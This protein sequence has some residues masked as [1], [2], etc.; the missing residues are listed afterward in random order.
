M[1]CYDVSG[2]MVKPGGTK[3]SIR[4][5][6]FHGSND[7][8]VTG[9]L[10]PAFDSEVGRLKIIWHTQGLRDAFGIYGDRKLRTEKLPPNMTT[11]LHFRPEL[12]LVNIKDIIQSQLFNGTLQEAYHFPSS[13]VMNPI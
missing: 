11:A 4:P 8:A 7:T 1:V 3:V 9:M 5:K 12:T 10:H 2:I 13:F 6:L